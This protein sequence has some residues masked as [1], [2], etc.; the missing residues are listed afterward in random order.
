[1]LATGT[2]ATL[3]GWASAVVVNTGSDAENGALAFTHTYPGGS[4][5]ALTRGSGTV[6]CAGSVLPGSAVTPGGVSATDTLTNGGTLSAARLVSDLRGVSCGPEQL[7]NAK[8]AA[9]PMLPRYDVAFEQG[10]PWGGSAAATFS[11]G[12]YAADVLPTV[13]GSLLGASYAFGVWFKVANGYA[14]GGPLMS[15]AVSPVDG[16]AV[17][18]SPMLWMDT[19]GKIR[20]RVSG[21]LGTSSSGVSAAAYNDGAWHLAILSVSAVLVS[22]PTLYVDA[23]AGVTSLGLAALTGANAYWHLGFADFTGIAGAPAATLPGSLAGAFVAASSVSS[24]TRSNL[25]G[26]ASAAAYASLAS[27]LSGAVHLWM[28][29]DTGT[30]TYAGALPVIGATSPCTMVDLA[31][32][33]TSPAGTIAPAGTRLSA[34][35]DGTWHTVAAPAPGGSQSLVATASRHATWNAYVAGLRLHVPVQHRIQSAPAG[36]AWTRTF[37]FADAT[38]VVIG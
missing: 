9:D 10:D 1:M 20:F 36:T 24:G 6:P 12:A 35:A 5:S 37:S 3:G 19:A 29:G 30:T 13:T 21:T 27:G 31:W 2:R 8:T 22:T 38:S 26:A 4:C 17:A 11:N 23:A 32:T 7:A 25:L 33:A 28:L 16:S 15:L 18:S 14:G 34:F